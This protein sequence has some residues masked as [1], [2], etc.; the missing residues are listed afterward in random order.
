MENVLKIVYD[1]SLINKLL[2]LNDMEKILDILVSHKCLNEYVLGMDVQYV[3]SNN[4]ASYSNYSRRI[5]IF[6]D[7]LNEMLN[8]IE[9]SIIDNN[10]FE[11]MLYKNLQ[12]LQII[13]HEVEHANQQMIVNMNNSFEALI[14]KL[15]FLVNNRYEYPLY[16]YCPEERLA[17]IKSFSEILVLMQNLDFKINKVK[18]FFEIEKLQRQLR[19]YHL[20]NNMVNIPLKTFFE[21]GNKFELSKSLDFCYTSN[22]ELIYRLIYGLNISKKEYGEYMY[23]LV[24]LLGKNYKNRVLIKRDFMLY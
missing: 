13:M 23:K 9:S 12:L 5:T 16:E 6:V 20:K 14:L 8:C 18:Y 24:S 19:G 3:R 7:K 22:K 15:S 2:D 4:I 17:E 1:K 10:G 11:S 21:I